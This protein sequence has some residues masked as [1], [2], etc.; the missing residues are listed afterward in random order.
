M[1]SPLHCSCVAQRLRR[2]LSTIPPIS[3][4]DLNVTTVGRKLYVPPC[5]IRFILISSR[6]NECYNNPCVV[7]TFIYLAHTCL[8]VQLTLFCAICLCMLLLESTS[9]LS[10]RS[11]Y[12][13]SGRYSENIWCVCLKVHKLWTQY[14]LRA[15]TAS[16]LCS[17]PQI[18]NFL[19]P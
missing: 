8:N 17:F 15:P 9:Q 2:A 14:L 16:L 12:R 7:L 5:K 3:G 19:P 18:S 11:S 6:N 10:N 13:F 1:K 4:T